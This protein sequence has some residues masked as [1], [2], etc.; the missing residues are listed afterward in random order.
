MQKACSN[1]D[2]QDVSDPGTNQSLRCLTCQIGRDGVHSTWYD[3]KR[4]SKF[5]GG[6]HAFVF[7]L[8]PAQ[9]VK[10]L[11][12]LGQKTECIGLRQRLPSQSNW[13]VT[14]TLQILAA[15]RNQI[16]EIR[17]FCWILASSLWGQ[18]DQWRQN[19]Q[20]L[21]VFQHLWLISIE[22][23]W[24]S[25][26]PTRCQNEFLQKGPFFDDFWPVFMKLTRL[27]LKLHSPSW[28]SSILLDMTHLL[29]ASF[30]GK[31][32]IKSFRMPENDTKMCVYNDFYHFTN[33]HCLHFNFF[34]YQSMSINVKTTLRHRMLT[35]NLHFALKSYIYEHRQRQRVPK[36]VFFRRH[37]ELTM[38]RTHTNLN[39]M[40]FHQRTSARDQLYPRGDEAFARLGVLAN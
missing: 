38:S 7:L 1:W 14:E 40:G 5:V 26:E 3:R 37:T 27:V 6:L 29:M 25:R 18:L 15:N 33:I 12:F 32:V 2:S 8:F 30:V 23:H 19:S 22:K 16:H 24:K 9:F 35:F 17:H 13:S 4:P 10:D 39:S 31:T 36:F 34:C 11:V 28:F 21:A 20:E